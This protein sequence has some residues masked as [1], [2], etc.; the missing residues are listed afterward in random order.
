MYTCMHTYIPCMQLRK[1]CKWHISFLITK[2]LE[3]GNRLNEALRKCFPD[4]YP[5]HR[6]KDIV[7]YDLFT[8]CTLPP[9]SSGCAS[10]KM[11]FYVFQSPLSTKCNFLLFQTFLGLPYMTLNTPRTGKTDIVQKPTVTK[12]TIDWM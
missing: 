3:Y 12:A 6:H 11:Y 2:K 4:F 7:V 8:L 10:S 1:L 5:A 9:E